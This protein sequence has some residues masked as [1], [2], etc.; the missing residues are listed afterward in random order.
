MRAQ[1][2]YLFQNCKT[3]REKSSII[4]GHLC[5]LLK[6]TLSLLLQSGNL[7]MQ[8]LPQYLIV[9]RVVSMRNNVSQERI[10]NRYFFA[11]LVINEVFCFIQFFD[12]ER[13]L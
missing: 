1:R 11:R 7:I 9:D 2:Y 4:D 12:E 3:A 13:V 5:T 10:S 8:R 6:E